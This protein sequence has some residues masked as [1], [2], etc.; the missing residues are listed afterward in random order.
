VVATAFTLGP[1]I[2]SVIL[3]IGPWGWLFAINIPFGLVAIVIGLKTLPRIPRATRAFDFSWRIVSGELSWP[4]RPG[5]WKGSPSRAAWTC[6]D[7][8]CLAGF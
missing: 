4:F 2:A 6:I 1:T 3:A 7:R 8:T 5:D